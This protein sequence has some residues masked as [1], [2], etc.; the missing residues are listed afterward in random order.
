MLTPKARTLL[1][2]TP[3]GY[4]ATHCMNCQA[5]WTRSGVDGS[6]TVC[7]LDHEPVLD[8]MIDCSRYEPEQ[9]EPEPKKNKK[10]A[11]AA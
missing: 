3:Q 8:G 4:A 11:D 10:K 2:K 9:P 7:L 5:G 1:W 6:I